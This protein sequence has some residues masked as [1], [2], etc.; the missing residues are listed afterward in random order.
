MA[1]EFLLEKVDEWR[2]EIPKR[3]GM[4]VP[5]LIYAD[6]KMINEI[7][8]G[9]SFKQVVNVAHLPGILKYSMAMPDIHWG[10]GF[11]I[12]GVAAFDCSDGIIS[13]GGVGYDINCGV[14]LLRSNLTKN[15]IN[16]EEVIEALFSNVPSGV[17]SKGNIKLSSSDLKKVLIKGAQWA[18]EHGYG[19]GEDLERIEDGGRIEEAEPHS[20]SNR[21]HERGKNQLGTV[22]SGNHFTEIGYVEEIY[23]SEIA[24]VFGLALNQITILIHSGSR[25]LGYQVCDDYLAGMVKK[26]SKLGISIPDRQ[27]ACAELRSREGQDYYGA[28]AAAANYAFANRQIITY[29]VRKTFEQTLKISP[30]DLNLMLV[31][32]VSHN[33]A[34][35][36]E[37]IVDGKKRKVC[38]HRKGATRA[39]GPGHKSIPEVYRDVGQP[40]LIPGDM[41]NNSFV[42]VGTQ[43]AMDETFGSTCH[44]AG[45]LMSRNQAKKS[46]AGKEI[47]TELEKAGIY[48]RSASKSTLKE[49]IPEAYKDVSE[50]VEVVHQAG[51]SQKVAKLKPLGAIKG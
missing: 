44:G 14:R 22:G 25:G 48:V 40:V 20:V 7:K 35:F 32:D 30:K 12:G 28:M 18:V 8:S 17:G 46:S 27:L 5:G 39:F 36:E 50:V 23:D 4:N 33:I 31:Y 34:K 47:R 6:S 45:R 11:P 15:E 19:I 41:K 3:E 49:E 51:I 10:Y 21:A 29:L 38:V 2:W 16:V 43:R 37:H 26:V 9:E 42:L 24:S 1:Q 13:P